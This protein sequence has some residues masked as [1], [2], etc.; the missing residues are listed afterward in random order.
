M[1]AVGVAGGQGCGR[2]VSCR[3]QEGLTPTVSKSTWCPPLGCV[4]PLVGPFVFGYQLRAS[5]ARSVS[6]RSGSS[7][8]VFSRSVGSVVVLDKLGLERFFAQ[9][10]GSMCHLLCCCV[11]PSNVYDP[12]LCGFA[13]GCLASVRLTDCTTVASYPWNSL[14]VYPPL[15]C[16]LPF[17]TPSSSDWGVS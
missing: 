7:R 4:V 15:V 2:E 6:S 3:G 14:Y 13:C 17:V 16:I 12:L 5:F 1:T 11:R 9:S 8:P 10:T